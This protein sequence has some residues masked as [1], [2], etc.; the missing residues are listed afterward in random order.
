MNA[1]QRRA[2]RRWATRS[3]AACLDLEADEI[4]TDAEAQDFAETVAY[5]RWIARSFWQGGNSS[6]WG[7]DAEDLASMTPI[8]AAAEA[9]DAW[10][11]GLR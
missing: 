8:E 1:R 2:R 3:I 9:W 11:Q 4:V 5:E 7:F 6:T 10:R